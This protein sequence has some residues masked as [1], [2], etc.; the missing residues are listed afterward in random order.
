MAVFGFPDIS[1]KRNDER[2]IEIDLTEDVDATI[3]DLDQMEQNVYM[4][5]C[6]Q[7][8]QWFYTEQS[9]TVHLKNH[10]LPSKEI[11]ENDKAKQDDKTNGDSQEKRIEKSSKGK[12]F[13][14]KHHDDRNLKLQNVLKHGK[15]CK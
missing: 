6:K 7:C 2:Q 8:L 4:K 15:I 13:Q 5:Y 10:H 3:P 14:H 9:Y 11:N 1:K 12:N